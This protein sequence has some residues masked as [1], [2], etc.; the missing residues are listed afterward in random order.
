SVRVKGTSL[1][2][3]TDVNGAYVLDNVNEGATLIFS[4]IGYLSQEV[5][6]EG[7]N[8]IS[9]VLI[10]D[11]SDLEEVVVV[12]YGT[13]KKINLTGSVDVISGEMLAD[14]PAVNITDLIKGTSPNTNITMGVNGGEPGASNSVNIRG[15]GSISGNSSPLVLVDGVEM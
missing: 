11:S 7:Q 6:V 8:Q 1:G 9:I 2:T 3:V 5:K 10:E 15:V 14:R 4:F 12:G 13:Q